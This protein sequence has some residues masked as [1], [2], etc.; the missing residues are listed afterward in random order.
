MIK[1]KIFDF[2][3]MIYWHQLLMGVMFT[4]RVTDGLYLE[5]DIVFSKLLKTLLALA[6]NGEKVL[7][8]IQKRL[9]AIVL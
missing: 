9:M 3:L 7:Q 1:L 2:R 4:L 6:Q 8:F 5:E